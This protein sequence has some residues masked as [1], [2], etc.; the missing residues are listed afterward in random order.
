MKTMFTST[1]IQNVD[2]NL[3][4][5]FIFSLSPI[6]L[7]SKCGSGFIMDAERKREMKP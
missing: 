6:C 3:K 4:D 5:L 7:R 1:Q 2:S